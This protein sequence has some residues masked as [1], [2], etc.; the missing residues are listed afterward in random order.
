MRIGI[1]KAILG[2]PAKHPTSGASEGKIREG[3]RH[4]FSGN[5]EGVS[6]NKQ[7]STGNKPSACETEQTSGGGREQ[8][9]TSPYK[10]IT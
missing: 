5:T 9:H 1:I 3:V 2:G 8:V 4:R 7:I 6:G 10:S